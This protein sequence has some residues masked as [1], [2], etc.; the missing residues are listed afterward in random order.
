MAYGLP[1]KSQHD[2]LVQFAEQAFTAM[3]GAAAPGKYL[4]NIISPLQ[5]VPDWMPGAGFKDVAREIRRQLLTLLE[6][7][8]RAT[9]KTMVGHYVGI[10]SLSL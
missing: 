5:H 7:P 6:E 10:Q 8:Y 9:L 1:V 3:A 4:V 2:P